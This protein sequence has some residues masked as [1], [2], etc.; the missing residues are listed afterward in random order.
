MNKKLKGISMLSF[1]VSGMIGV[2]LL[3]IPRDVAIYAKTDSWISLILIGV[4]SFLNAFALY[5]LCLKHPGL[6]FP[7]INEK[8]FG[9][10]LGKLAV[11]IILTYKIATIGLSLRLFNDNVNIFL[12]EN[13]PR[14]VV[15]S[16]M[17]GSCVYCVTRDIRS[18]S[19]VLDILLPIILI[20]TFFL[21]LLSSKGAEPKNLLPVFH[22]GI[23]PVIKGAAQ[24]IDPILSISIIAY[25]MPYFEDIKSTKKWIFFGVGI[26]AAIYLATMVMC[27]TVFG[28]EEIERLTYPVL[29]LSQSLKLET[30]IFERAETLFMATWIPI[31]LTTI[32]VA[33]ISTNLNLKTLFN[34]QKNRLIIYGQIPVVMFIALLPRNAREVSTYLNYENTVAVFLNFVYFPLLL[35]TAA[36]KGRKVKK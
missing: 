23:R 29:S 4:L 32:V 22:V 10:V 33:Y 9:K 28:H 15:I 11:F 1:V 30:Q 7:Q 12:L 17:L 5:W 36:I 19:I 35:I 3:T 24:V 34:T 16:I 18:I 8:V 26:S 2:R 31:T 20:I 13:T 6:N 14:L 25:V 21:I 27:I